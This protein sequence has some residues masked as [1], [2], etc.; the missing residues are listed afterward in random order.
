MCGIVGLLT[1]KNLLA[2]IMGELM[3]NADWMSERGPDSAIVTQKRWQTA[4]VQ[5]PGRKDFS[6]TGQLRLETISGY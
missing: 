6:Q 3:N 5:S 2:R 1:Q 4:T